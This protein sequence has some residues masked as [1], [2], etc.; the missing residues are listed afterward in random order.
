MLALITALTTGLLTATP[1]DAPADHRVV[2]MESIPVRC[3]PGLDY[4]PWRTAHQGDVVRVVD[5]MPGWVRVAAE[6]PVFADAWGWIRYPAGESGRFELTDPKTGL[7]HGTIEII[8]PNMQSDA[9]ADAFKSVCLIPEGTTI[10]VLESSTSDAHSPGDGDWVVHRVVMPTSATGWVAESA[11]RTATPEEAAGIKVTFRPM[12]DWMTMQPSSPIA[13]WQAWAKDRPKWIA[14]REA[15]AAKEA[16]AIAAAEAAKAAEVVEMVK[17]EPAPDPAPEPPYRN[18]QWE[19]LE[20]TLI[21]TPLHRLDAGAVAQLRAGYVAV[22]DAEAKA[23]PEIAESATLRLRQLELARDLNDSRR[24]IESALARIQRSSDDL[25]AQRQRLDES[26]DYVIR[27]TLAVSPVFDGVKRPLYYRLKDPFS[28]RSLAYVSPESSVDV[29][30]MLGQ[31][32]GIVG[33]MAWDP[34]WRVMTVQ[35]ERVDLVS[36]SPPQ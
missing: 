33:K 13:D 29:R 24:Q 30:G 5:S 3:G 27:G 2:T 34:T 12:A 8:A 23:H 16:A 10:P 4:Y 9:T 28:G 17:I 26:P 25:A 14:A 18:E 11:V 21:A 32:V 20:A 35:P 31:R 15:A 19:S 1:Q 6:G 7:S 36:V 22:V